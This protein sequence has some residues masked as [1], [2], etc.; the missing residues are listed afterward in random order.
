MRSLVPVLLLVSIFTVGGCAGEDRA[1]RGRPPSK[2]MAKPA[3]KAV[4]AS[5]ETAILAGGCFWG[6]EELLRKIPGVVD[7]E[8]GYTAGAESVRVVFD[9]SV[10]TYATL[11]ER[12]FFRMHDPTTRNRQGNDVGEQYRSAIFYTTDGQR[13]TAEQ[14]KA[15]VAA[16]GFWKAPLTTEIKA[17]GKFEPAESFHQDY[18]QKNPEG[19]TCHF[20][21]K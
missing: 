20:I 21:R 5:T 7:T 15:R 10:L 14:V 17:A 3:V 18:L 19:Y 6:M 13:A 1:D 4:P 8:A 2:P 16:S 11:L 9:P 12:W